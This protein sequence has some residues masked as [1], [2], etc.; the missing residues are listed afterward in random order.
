M[1]ATVSGCG[2]KTGE[3]I[4]SDTRAPALGG[5]MTL[6]Q[7]SPK[8]AV[9][10]PTPKPSTPLPYPAPT[11]KPEPAK[12]VKT[13]TIGIQSS[14]FSPNLIY[15]ERG[16]VVTWI[17]YDR[18]GHT[19]TGDNGGPSS[20]TIGAGKKYSYTFN[21]IGTFNYHC[22]LHPTMKATVVVTP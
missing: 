16:T 17:N 18:N 19:V 11:P 15:V 5:T 12:P 21:E 22:K 7:G 3:G 4:V 6:P 10:T 13:F 2:K 20:G 9:A 14:S 8:P 1:L